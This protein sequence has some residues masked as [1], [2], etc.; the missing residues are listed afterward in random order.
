MDHNGKRI[1]SIALT[2]VLAAGV[3]GPR[4]GS[5]QEDAPLVGVFLTVTEDGAAPMVGAFVERMSDLGYVEGDNVRYE[6][7]FTDGDFG[8]IGARLGELA[9]LEPALILTGGSRTLAAPELAALEVPVVVAHGRE[10]V[11]LDVVGNL[12]RP[13]GRITGILQPDYAPEEEFSLIQALVPDAAKV[14]YLMAGDLPRFE[15]DY[16]IVAVGAA[17][18]DL[19]VVTG[20]ATTPEEAVAAYESVS[21][22]DVDAM[23]VASGAHFF[24]AMPG[25]AAAAR[26][27]GLPTLYFPPNATDEGGLIS[28][29]V[30]LPGFYRGAAGLVHQIL[31]GAEPSDIAIVESVPFVIRVNMT[32]ARELGLEIPKDVLSRAV[33]T[34]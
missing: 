15:Y 9:E 33:V 11:F 18:R 30:D 12:E 6:Y 28:Q 31:E 17:P 32:A 24:V 5:A 2:L 16:S 7:R 14:G 21:S 10:G 3:T 22:Q 29:G 13:E 20:E 8:L 34:E 4:A 23:V 26:E 27:A 1:S 25:L 19:E